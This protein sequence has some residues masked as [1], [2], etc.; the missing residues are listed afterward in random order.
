M[1]SVKL[2]RDL[3]RLWRKIRFK[4]IYWFSLIF[5]AFLFVVSGESVFSPSTLSSQKIIFA[6]EE[7]LELTTQVN[8]LPILN[9]KGIAFPNHTAEAIFIRERNSGE[10][11]F[12]ENE[13]VQRS[14]ASLT[15]MA[16]AIVTIENCDLSKEIIVNNVLKDGSL[17]GL[18]NGEKVTYED[19]LYGM[20][21]ASGN[22]AA[23]ML[24]RACFSSQE[25]A[26]ESIQKKLEF[27]GL[28]DTNYVN[29]SGL[30]ADNH[31]S[32]AYDL[33]FLAE[34]LLRNEKLA[35][36]V[37]TKEI[38][39][40]SIDLK[41]WYSLKSSNDLL[42]ENPS[43]YGVKTGY[44]ESA[45]QCLI[46]AYKKGDRDFMITILGSQDRFTD[47]EAIINWIQSNY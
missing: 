7:V 32:S 26:V 31:Y 25:K 24:S 40:V 1:K 39:L 19:L 42:F 44:T 35:E 41:R 43:V 8:P 6:K 11:I 5:L 21:V 2:K 46:L 20:L 37:N 3:Y 27:L 36:I 18:E 22:D 10:I 45:G 12:K 15:K 47:G 16:T 33:T 23:E 13:H 9:C 38:T 34:V 29:V 28:H 14:P 17:M 30:P 4:P